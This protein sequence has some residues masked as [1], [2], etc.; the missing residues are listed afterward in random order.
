[1]HELAPAEVKARVEVA[2]I[3]LLD[4]GTQHDVQVARQGKQVLH[5]GAVKLDR[6]VHNQV[7][8]KVP[9]QAEF[10][11][12]EQLDAGGDRPCHP[13]AVTGEVAIAIAKG[14]IH[15][16]QAD[17]ELA[18]G[19]HTSAGVGRRTPPPRAS[20]WAMPDAISSELPMCTAARGSA[21]RNAAPYVRFAIR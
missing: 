19:A 10:G 5:G 9:G 21:L 8:Q 17:R 2:V 18:V 1:M 4:H 12:D 20:H 6:A 15:L 7:P 14:G 16:G 3:R 11:K 13:L